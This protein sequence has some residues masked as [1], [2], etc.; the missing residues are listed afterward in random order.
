MGKALSFFLFSSIIQLDKAHL[1]LY[2]LKMNSWLPLLNFLLI[3]ILFLFSGVTAFFGP[4][5]RI[6]YS[7]PAVIILGFLIASPRKEV[8]W[9]DW[10]LE[11][12][13]FG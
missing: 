2:P 13:S 5:S 4:R 1:F 9:L 8:Y 7:I 10:L 3:I 11:G 6:K 12:I